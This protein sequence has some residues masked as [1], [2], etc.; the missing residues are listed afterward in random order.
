MYLI[1]SMMQ[2]TIHGSVSVLLAAN[3]AALFDNIVIIDRGLLALFWYLKAF[4]IMGRILA[5]RKRLIYT[6]IEQ[7]VSL[8]E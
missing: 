6:L 7:S 5:I 8:I 2:S 1:E 3:V 4:G